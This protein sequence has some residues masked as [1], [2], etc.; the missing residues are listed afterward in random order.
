[1]VEGKLEKAEDYSKEVD[2]ALK[3]SFELAKV[4]ILNL[5]KEK[6]AICS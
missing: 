5:P 6:S 1:M 3:E 4:I 2:V